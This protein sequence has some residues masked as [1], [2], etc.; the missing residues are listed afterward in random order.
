MSPAIQHKST[1]VKVDQCSLCAK[2]IYIVLRLTNTCNPVN[3]KPAI[4][5][6]LEFNSPS[7]ASAVASHVGNKCCWTLHSDSEKTDVSKWKIFLKLCIRTSAV[8]PMIH[9]RP[10]WCFQS[11]RRSGQPWVEGHVLLLCSS[12]WKKNTNKQTWHPSQKETWR[13]VEPVRL[14]PC[15]SPILGGWVGVD[16]IK[17]PLWLVERVRAGPG[18]PTKQH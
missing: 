14:K 2:V 4:T 3:H 17:K 18:P 5:D 12:T 16:F 13:W 15:Y 1:L 11:Q 9:Q 6:S 7:V 8:L 10:P